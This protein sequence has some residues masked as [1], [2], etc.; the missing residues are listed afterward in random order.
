MERVG[1]REK[2]QWRGRIEETYREREREGKERKTW[3]GTEK[4][5]IKRGKGRV[6]KKA[7]KKRGKERNK[8]E[9]KIAIGWEKQERYFL[10]FGPR[11][12]EVGRE[13][14]EKEIESRSDDEIYVC[15]KL[16]L[17]WKRT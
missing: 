12:R 17:I 8:K 5:K 1:K 7:K 6:R 10:G 14:G 13:E 2:E 15:I 11:L 3:I 9:R 16:I 4:G